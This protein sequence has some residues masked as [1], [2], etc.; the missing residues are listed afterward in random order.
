MG[1]VKNDEQAQHW[2]AQSA[3]KGNFFAQR[4]LGLIYLRNQGGALAAKWLA[5]TPLDHIDAYT[6]PYFAAAEGG[7]S[8]AQY[9]TGQ[10]YERRIGDN[11]R[12]LHWYRLAAIQDHG[13]ACLSLAAM[14]RHGKGTRRDFAQARSWLEKAAALEIESAQK[15]LAE[16]DVSGHFRFA[17]WAARAAAKAGQKPL[18]EWLVVWLSPW[19]RR[20]QAVWQNAW[21]RFCRR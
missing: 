7:A 11:V 3:D 2:F 20:M 17:G 9:K 4:R 21:E 12:A 8:K 18:H 16:Q 10:F 6:L 5:K 15:T 14:Y 13:E 1:V 19:L